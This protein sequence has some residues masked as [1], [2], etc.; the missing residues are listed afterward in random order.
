MSRPALIS[1]GISAGGPKTL[2]Q[3]FR[4]LPQLDAAIL[5]VQHMPR[6]I[7]Q[8]I[9]KSL[10]GCTAM[11]VLLA[12]DGNHLAP[13]TVYIAPSEVHLRV[14]NNE[15]IELL[16]GPKVCYVRPSID[17][18]MQSFVAR[19]DDRIMG[20]V[21]TGLGRDGAN[22]IAHVKAIGGTTVVQDEKT[23]VIFGMPK[24]AIDTGQ[25]DSI[26][27]PDGIR[28]KLISFAGGCNPGFSVTTRL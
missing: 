25:V 18:T 22:G 26:L 23:S 3:V 28:Q 11:D 10:D 19:D 16:D 5:V 6:H 9:R 20:I 14:K 1:I 12:E 4:D 7:N 8:W 15:R 27:S 24:T 13:G 2:R 21:M 17:V